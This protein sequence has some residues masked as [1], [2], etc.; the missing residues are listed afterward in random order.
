MQDLRKTLILQPDESCPN[1]NQNLQDFQNL[2]NG[3]IG[4]GGFLIRILEFQNYQNGGYLPESPKE[5]LK[6]LI[7]IR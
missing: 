1:I 5:V 4:N 3:W 2:Q 7:K 6:I